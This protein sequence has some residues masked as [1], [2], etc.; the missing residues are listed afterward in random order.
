ML[1]S[2]REDAVLQR[3]QDAVSEAA[4]RP[5]V[6]RV[7]ETL[8]EVSRSMQT[9]MLDDAAREAKTACSACDPVCGGEYAGAPT[10]TAAVLPLPE[11]LPI[12]FQGEEGSFSEAALIQAYGVDAPRRNYP[13]FADVF[14]ALRRGEIGCGV[15]P[16][17]NS[18][19]GGI[20]EVYDLILRGWSR[21]G[22]FCP[23]IPPCG[24][25]PG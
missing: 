22:A 13:R 18:S 4:Y 19:T 10:G 8:M 3:A 17:E 2:S 16:I 23:A 24:G 25:Y 11:G 7:F 20:N 1:Q 21:A 12:G 5:G 6:R 15:L 14:E 9:G